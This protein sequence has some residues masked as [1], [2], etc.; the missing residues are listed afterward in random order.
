MAYLRRI[1]LMHKT[2][3]LVVRVLSQATSED[4]FITIEVQWSNRTYDLDGPWRMVTVGVGSLAQLV[5]L[6][7]GQ[8]YSSTVF[9][10]AG[11]CS[12]ESE[13][14]NCSLH[15]IYDPTLSNTAIT[16]LIRNGTNDWAQPVPM[17]GFYYD[18]ADDILVSFNTNFDNYPV[19][20]TGISITDSAT[21]SYPKGDIPV[22]VGSLCLGA[23]LDPW[24]FPQ[25]NNNTEF[26]APVLPNYYAD[27]DNKTTASGSFGMHI[28]AVEPDLPSSL[29]YGGYD[30][31][32]VVG[33]VATGY[34]PSHDTE[35]QLVDISIGGLESVA[36]EYDIT[37]PSG[38]IADYVKSTS[39]ASFIVQINPGQP[40]LV[41]PKPVCDSLTSKLLVIHD[42]G[43]ALYTWNSM[44]PRYPYFIQSPQ[45]LN[46][47]FLSND[48]STVSIAVP[49][50]LQNLTLSPPLVNTTT[51]YFPCFTATDPQEGYWLGRAFLQSAF[52][53]AYSLTIHGP[54]QWLL[55]QAPGPGL[56][57]PDSRVMF[58]NDVIVQGD[59]PG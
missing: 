53:G 33:T 52:F 2:L 19:R 34:I 28:G 35:V 36:D 1:L 26:T 24:D 32:R 23:S 8:Y 46:S 37:V 14:V 39:A 45:Y 44:S 41:L 9:S 38:V 51:F 20:T 18:V 43:L 13:T 59:S 11:A 3:S 50:M 6:I 57:A 42:D 15:S 58:Y 54:A 10:P 12:D 25:N 7:P 22:T 16:N 47:S 40:Y 27:N 4:G 17:T 21:M 30:A 31:S 55:A 56:R 48:G 5:D 49:L 29:W